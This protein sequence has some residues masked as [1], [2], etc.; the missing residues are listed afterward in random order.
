VYA[1]SK[2]ALAR[3]VRRSAVRPEWA[4]KGIRLN[5]VA[6][7]ATLTPLL[8]GGLDDDRLGTAIR[9]LPIPLGEFGRADEIAA[10]VCF[11]LSEAASFCCG[12]IL[13]ADGGSDALLRPDRI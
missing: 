1:S 8:Q 4:G 10:A 12:T 11:L 6:P 7:G 5:A 13:F 9:S 3:F 2:L